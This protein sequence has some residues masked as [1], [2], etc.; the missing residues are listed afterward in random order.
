MKIGVLGTGMVGKAIASRLIELGHQVKM[1]SRTA[2]N[3]KAGEWLNKAG[4]PN[5]SQGT[6]SD[7]ATY[8]ELIIN[9]TSGMASLEVLKQAGAENLKAKVLID[10]AN[11][12]DFSKGMPPSLSVCNTDSLG[13]QIQRTY[14]DLKVVKTLNTMNC[15]LMVNPALLAGDHDVFLCGNDVQAKAKVQ[16]LLKSFGWKSPIDL[17]DLTAAR[18]TEMILPVWL[19]LMGALGT[20]NFN[21][22]I[23]K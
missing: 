15:N 10:I 7:A 19:K 14:P 18:G 3:E 22:K 20:A 4:S 12:L 1:G 8:G 5:A 9:C 11:P 21:F 6:F 17:G 16:D 23:V 13:E 2:N